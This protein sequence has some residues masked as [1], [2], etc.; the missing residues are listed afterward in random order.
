MRTRKTFI[1]IIFNFL[2]Q[3]VGIVTGLILPPLIVGKFGSSLNGL[4]STIKQMMTYV[5]LTGAGI[6]ASSTYALYKPLVDENHK[7]G[8]AHV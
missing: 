4:V 1:N 2:Q 8:R 6:A 5:Q 3:L 7:I